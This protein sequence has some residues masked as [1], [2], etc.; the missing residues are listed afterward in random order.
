MDLKAEAWVFA[1]DRAEQF[2]VALE[3]II[4]NVEV[5]GR[6]V[7][8]VRIDDAVV[9][10]VAQRF[11]FG[12]RLVQIVH[13][14]VESGMRCCLD[15]RAAEVKIVHDLQGSRVSEEDAEAGVRHDAPV[16]RCRRTH[17]DAA[18]ERSKLFQIRER[19][20]AHFVWTRLAVAVGN[21]VV[22]ANIMIKCIRPKVR[23]QVC[24]REYGT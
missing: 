3:G 7:Q 12:R 17:V 13:A 24:T 15:G 22:D 16:S 1:R 21:K 19:G 11:H 14:F 6:N 10:K 2:V 5:E 4:R 20:A 23:F 9:G 18:F 8:F